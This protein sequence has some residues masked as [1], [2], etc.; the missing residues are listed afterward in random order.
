MCAKGV[1]A[2]SVSKRKKKLPAQ[3][4]GGLYKTVADGFVEAVPP[5]A[6]RDG[7]GIFTVEL[8]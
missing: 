5:R 7:A 2:F 8:T 6:F 1:C 4:T 3:K